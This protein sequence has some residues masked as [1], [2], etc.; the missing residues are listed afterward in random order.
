MLRRAVVVLISLTSATALLGCRPDTVLL[1]FEPEVGA[2]YRYRYELEGTITRTVE[3]EAPRT[4]S[5]Q[6]TVESV[7]TVVDHSEAGTV[8]DVTLRSSAAARPSTATVTVDRAG[9]LQAIQQVDGL[10]PGTLGL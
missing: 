8:L 7:Q 10:P 2:T 3:G 4:T 9:S 6:V 5:L 1:G